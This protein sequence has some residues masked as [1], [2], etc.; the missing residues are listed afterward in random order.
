MTGGQRRVGDPERVG[1]VAPRWGAQPTPLLGREQDG[2]AARRH[3]LRHDVRLLTL[4]GPP[5]VG[6][7]R[8]ALALAAGLRDEF[9][10]GVSV[11]E[12]APVLDAALVAPTIAAALGLQEVAAQP[13]LTAVRHY[14]A[15]KQALLVLDNFEQVLAAGVQVAEILAGCPD[16][17][18]L[19][20]SRAPLRVRWEYEFP[21]PPLALPPPGAT[22]DPAELLRFPAITLF[23]ERARALRPDFALTPADAPVVAAL[24]ARLDGLPLA[25]ELAAARARAW[26]PGEIL[27]HLPRRLDRLGDGPRDLPPRHRTLRAAIAWS[28]RLLSDDDRAV[29]RRLAV[30]AG[31]FTAEAAAAVC[32]DPTAPAADADTD[33]GTA[34]ALARLVDASLVAVH[35][36]AG[37]PPRYRLLETIR[38]FAA[39][40]LERSGEL[41]ATRRRHARHFLALGREAEPHLTG[42]SRGPWLDRLYAELDNLRAV[43]VASEGDPGLVEAALDLAGA[44]WWFWTFR[45]QVTEGRRWS[46]ALLA[47]DHAATPMRGRAQTLLAAG[48]LAW[49][50]GD[51]AA[52]RPYLE[53]SAALCRTLGERAGLGY[54][55][56]VLGRAWGYQGEAATARALLGRGAAIFREL[57]E[58]WGLALTL[59]DYGDATL[60]VDPAAARRLLEESLGLFRRLGDGWGVALALTSL[61]RL[62]LT[63]GE[64]PAARAHVEEALALRRAE[65]HPYYVAISLASLGDIARCRRDIAQAWDRYGESL[66]LHLDLGNR[67]GI[68]WAKRG[69]GCAALAQGR[70]RPA[71][72]LLQ[73]SLDL[74]RE[75]GAKP[76]IAESLAALGGVLVRLGRHEPAAELFGAVDALVDETRAALGPA[77]RVGYDE[78]VAVARARIGAVALAAARARGRGL[79][80]DQAISRGMAVYVPPGAADAPPPD[81]GRAAANPLSRRERDVAALVARGLSNREI[82]AMLFITEGTA[83][84]HVKHILTKLGLDRRTQVAIWALGVGLAAD[85]GDPP[86]YTARGGVP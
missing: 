13:A 12:L 44:I 72:E 62:A 15:A 29:W 81:P 43:F 25:I 38:D 22:P 60:P 10:D 9:P 75:L 64:Y 50:Q 39:E 33:S 2:A 30:F 56:G 82:A 23:V 37:D 24:C 20:T 34:A 85:A 1:S 18:V 69:L 7:T 80:L 21:V 52:A 27:A 36:P 5:G 57:D 31:G 48:T 61:G 53:E 84:L 49:L 46:E 68:A 77:D 32:R 26:S 6:K 4:T 79:T 76:G 35:R 65:G 55:V 67:R 8:L 17:K 41:A 19:V 28:V 3:L 71:V 70:L 47:R 78:H 11:V 59:F 73:A 63:R 66:A 45:G 40:E 74:E 58:P 42:G 54:A 16:L 51:Y 14:L 86:R 83:N